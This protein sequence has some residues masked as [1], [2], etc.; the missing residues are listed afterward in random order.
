MKKSLIE[1]SVLFVSILKWVAVATVI[2]GLVGASTALFLKLLDLSLAF[3][4]GYPYYFLL[5]PAGMVVGGL[6]IRYLEPDARGY[7]IEKVIEA[8][9]RKGGRIRAGVVP[10][11]LAATILTIATG[12]A[13][14]HVSS[15]QSLH[16]TST[17]SRT[18]SVARACLS[19]G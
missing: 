13:I 18:N 7:G 9:P 2:G 8:V 6:V 3:S 17:C 11:K 4:T 14:H 19:G 16:R 15:V 10:V 1:E 5:L 12:G